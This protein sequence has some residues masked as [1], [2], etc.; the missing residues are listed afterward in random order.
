MTEFSQNY[1]SPRL[2]AAEA[3]VYIKQHKFDT[4][5]INLKEAAEVNYDYHWNIGNYYEIIGQK[6]SAI[7]NY[8]ILYQHDTLTYN[9]CQDRIAELK[10][11]KTKFLKELIFKDKERKVLMLH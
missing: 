11:V 5:L 2:L 4:A 1:R 9:Y 10:K 8:Q 7:S 6:D 3:G